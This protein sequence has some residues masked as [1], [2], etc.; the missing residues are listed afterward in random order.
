MPVARFPIIGEWGE[1]EDG[2]G[3]DARLKNAH[4]EVETPSIPHRNSE[5]GKK[6]TYAVKRW[7]LKANDTTAVA[8]GRG[9][10]V[11]KGNVYAVVGD[12]VYKNGSSIGTLATSTGRVYFDSAADGTGLLCVHDGANF[13]TI[14]TSDTITTEADPQIPSTIKP[15]LVVLDQY[16]LL[17]DDEGSVHNSDAG[18]VTSWAGDSINAELR[19]DAAVGIARYVNYLAVFGEETI[20]FLYNAANST[21]SPLSRVEGYGVLIGCPE[22]ATISNA[23]R[24]LMFVAEEPGAGRYVAAFQGGYVPERISTDTID[25]YLDAEGSNISNAYAYTVR[26][27]GKHF[28]VLTL[29]TT[30][31]KTF[32]YDMDLDQWYE[33]TSDVSDTET[34]FTGIDAASVNGQQ[35][36][37]DED[38]GRIY[39]WDPGTYQDNTGSAETI[40]V[41]IDT[42]KFDFA[43]KQTKFMWKLWVVG[44]LA[45]GTANLGVSWSDDDYGTFTTARNIDI[46]SENNR[47]RRLGRFKRRSFRLT[48]EANQPMRINALEAFTTLG[49]WAR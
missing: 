29:P 42:G 48:F 1:R 24:W 44:D 30:A 26:R 9:L 25:E 18:D 5:G 40:K 10:F 27:A 45:P 31:A 39:E 17:L 35:L 21:G 41:Q 15:G 11:W 20:E 7:G 43:T 13:Y 14:N 37:L 32:V 2:N 38:N 33:W 23:G 47:L 4:I 3:T 8:E 34:Y 16:A 12:T 36:I 6:V 49:H 28:Y 19:A 22:G 46:S